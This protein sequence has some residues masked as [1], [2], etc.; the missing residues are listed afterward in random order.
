MNLPPG[1][2]PSR[3][4]PAR[5]SGVLEHRLPSSGAAVRMAEDSDWRVPPRLGDEISE[6]AE[7]HA[8]VEKPGLE[9]RLVVDKVA[10]D[11]GSVGLFDE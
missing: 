11:Q 2:R 1:M 6:R 8:H 7:H 4:T 3:L 10:L 9:R 5:I